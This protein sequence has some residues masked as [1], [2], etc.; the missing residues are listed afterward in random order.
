MCTIADVRLVCPDMKRPFDPGG[1][2]N[3]IPGLSKMNRVVVTRRS[4][5]VRTT[6]RA[7]EMVENARRKTSAWKRTAVLPVRPSLN[8]ILVPFVLRI[9]P[10]LRAKKRDDGITIF[11]DVISGSMFVYIFITLFIY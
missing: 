4:V 8:A 11:C 10:G 6:P 1:I 9:I 5:L 3:R 2:L 7:L